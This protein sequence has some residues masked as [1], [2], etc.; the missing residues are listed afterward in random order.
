MRWG[1]KKRH[2]R[3]KE[4][5]SLVSAGF[6]QKMVKLPWETWINMNYPAI[7]RWWIMQH[8]E[9]VWALAG[10]ADRSWRW[11]GFQRLHW[12]RL[13]SCRLFSHF[14]ITRE[15]CGRFRPKWQRPEPSTVSIILDL[16]TV[17]MRELFLELGQ[18]N[19]NFQKS[20]SFFRHPSFRCAH[21]SQSGVSSSILILLR[22]AAANKV[23]SSQTIQT[24]PETLP[25]PSSSA[26][27]TANNRTSIYQKVGRSG[28][29]EE[30]FVE[31]SDT[32]NG[33]SFVKLIQL[34]SSEYKA[35]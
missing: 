18:I 12:T 13:S 9:F 3:I 26:V 22:I 19:V 16:E 30:G 28:G 6:G 15:S 4:R 33:F 14:L 5:T 8:G 29:T 31:L 23:R 1:N 21:Y 34:V 11:A 2:W 24:V 35:W 20:L 10:W 32:P 17:T 27:R 25:P 7:K